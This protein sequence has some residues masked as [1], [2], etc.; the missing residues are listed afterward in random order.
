LRTEPIRL[1]IVLSVAIF[2]DASGY[3]F[4]FWR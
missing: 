2:V 1:R 3:E 4:R